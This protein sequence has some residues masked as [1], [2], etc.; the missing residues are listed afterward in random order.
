MFDESVEFCFVI[1]EAFLSLE[2]FIEAKE[3]DNNI[4]LMS[5]YP[6][7]GCFIMSLAI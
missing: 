6:F 2:R 3:G 7:I 1:F 4:G 5:C